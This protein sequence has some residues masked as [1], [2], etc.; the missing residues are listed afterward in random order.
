MS[1]VYDWKVNINN[2]ELDEVCS[3]LENG[4]LVVFPTETV[5]GIGADAFNS[6]ACKKIFEAKGRPADNP[7]IAHV[8]DFDM[9]MGCVKDINEIERKL[10]DA[11]MPGP[12]TLILKKRENVPSEVT[13]G[14]DT[15]AVRM[16]D[17][18]IA[19]SIIK[20]FGKPIAAPSAN[21]SG[22][23][24]GTRIEDIKEE[25]E[26]NV[27]AFIDGGD[28]EIGLESTVVRVVNNV[29]VILRPGA[30]TKEDILKVIGNVEVDKHVLNDVK[31]N[32]K[33]LSPGMKHKHYS[34][35]T[36][37]VLLDV[38]NN[39][40]KKEI[41]KLLENK[42]IVILG[43]DS[44]KRNYDKVN[45]ISIG[46]DL[47]E[48][49]KNIFTKLRKIDE[50]NYNLILIEAVNLDGIGLAIMNRIIRTCGYNVIK[51]KNQVM[52]YIENESK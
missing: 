49:S 19:N 29:P 21:K 42:N 25:L 11:F 33:V 3:F 31:E 43:L 37:C 50:L 7:L 36:K 52:C 22:K 14:L 40:E 16:P 2:K 20:T 47:K 1:R 32:E 13:A 10:I 23:P 12:F 45:F 39:N 5:Y 30:I 44:D 8:S 4:E 18:K 15:V 28:T 35:R 51:N 24:S 27:S 41:N 17:N 48:F 9:L 46:E 38:K 26:K 6:L 34:P